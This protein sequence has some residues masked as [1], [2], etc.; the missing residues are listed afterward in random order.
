M[1]CPLQRSGACLAMSVA[2]SAWMPCLRT[3]RTRCWAFAVRFAG[4]GD[5][6]EATGQGGLH[7]NNRSYHAG[8]TLCCWPGTRTLPPTPPS[9]FLERTPSKADFPTSCTWVLALPQQRT[10]SSAPAMTPVP[11]PHQVVVSGCLMSE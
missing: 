11:G 2:P 4:W 5:T 3:L 9:V 6:F 1:P 10:V 7:S 8:V